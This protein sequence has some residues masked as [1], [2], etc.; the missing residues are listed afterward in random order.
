MTQPNPRTG[1]ELDLAYQDAVRAH[2]GG[3][4][5]RAAPLYDMLLTHAPD[6]PVLL[7]RRGVLA[8]QMGDKPGALRWLQQAALRAPEDAEVHSNL[9]NAL[10]DVGDPAARAIHLR[11]A[12]LAPD[13]PGVQM[14]CAGYLATS[15]DPAPAIPLLEKIVA[16]APDDAMAWG[17]L[18]DAQRT[19]GDD[20]AAA[21]AMERALTLN[22]RDPDRWH[23]LGNL[24]YGLGAFGRAAKAFRASLDLRPNHA[25]TLTNLGLSL[26][27]TP[28]A[29]ALHERALSLDPGL[30]VAEMNRAVHHL[31]VGEPEEGWRAYEVRHRMPGSLQR[32]F[33]QPRWEGEA[34]AADQPLLLWAEQ[35]TGD[36]LLKL[37]YVK[38]AMARARSVILEM[39]PGSRALAAGLPP[40]LTILER[41]EPLPP[42]ARHLPTSSLPR[43][44]D[45]EPISFPY[46]SPAS[47]AKARWEQRLPKGGAP[48]VGLIWAGNPDQAN[49]K[50]RSRRLAEFAPLFR[51]DQARFYSLQVGEARAQI[52]EFS[53]AIEDLADGLSD[54]GETAAALAQLDLLISIDTGTLNLAGALNCEAWAILPPN[55]CW[56]WR[57]EGELSPCYPSVRLFRQLTPERGDA[58]PRDAVI[59]RLDHAFS[60]WLNA[61]HSRGKTAP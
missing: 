44:F 17:L 34:L 47:D 30:L 29:L 36:L 55:P 27:G 25:P 48:K 39:H 14:N 50:L 61:R 46:L 4:F 8:R 7:L 56:R 40:G 21:A 52:A 53:G 31:R 13:H 32:D 45:K 51:H 6:H 35:G 60:D 49:D 19:L 59:A 43:Y 20:E 54:F 58:E 57:V 16:R 18:G 2:G 11:A 38:P 22:P 12:Q 26:L 24:L 5:A 28:E 9:G 41:G 42:F 15:D 37:R 3:D 1:A 33:P 10:A 23:N